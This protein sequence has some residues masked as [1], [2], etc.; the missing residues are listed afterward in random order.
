MSDGLRKF[1]GKLESKLRPSIVIMAS[2]FNLTS[3]SVLL[4][5]LESIL[6]LGFEPFLHGRGVK[7]VN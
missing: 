6:G 5:S 1:Y 7:L 2:E 3:S 4:L